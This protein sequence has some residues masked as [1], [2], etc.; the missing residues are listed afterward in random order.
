VPV[1]DG[2][3]EATPVEVELLSHRD[4]PAALSLRPEDFPEGEPISNETV[5][6]TTHTGTTWTPRCT[7]G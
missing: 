6:L 1:L 5:T 4:A 2:P 7:T 3:S